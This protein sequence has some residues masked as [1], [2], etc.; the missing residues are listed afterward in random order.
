MKITYPKEAQDILQKLEENGFEAFLV[1]GS[2][3]DELLGLTP[4]DF[5]ITTSATPFEMKKIFPDTID[6]GIKHGTLTIKVNEKQFEVT[7]YRIDSE[8][9]DSRHPK[10]VTF[11]TSLKED[12]KRRDFTINAFAYSERT[13]FIDYFNGLKDLKDKRIRAIGDPKKRF[14]EDALRMLRAIRFSAQLG[15][16]I[17]EETKK[18]IK[19]EAYRL[20]YISKERIQEEFL[21]ILL[22]PHP[23][24]FLLAYQLGVTK[25]ILPEFDEMMNTSQETPYHECSVGE[26]TIKAIL[27]SPQ[28]EIIR[29]ALFFHDYGK[30]KTKTIDENGIA[31]FYNHAPKGAFAVK[32][33]L[34]RLKFPKKISET[35]TFLVYHHNDEFLPQKKYVRRAI[36]KIT[37]ALFPYYLAIQKADILAQSDYKKEEALAIN[38]QIT[39]LFNEIMEEQDCLSLKDLAVKGD[40][41]LKNG[42][43][44]KNIGKVLET[45]LMHILDEPIDNNKEYLLSHL[46]EFL[47]KGEK[48]E[49]K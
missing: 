28:D 37:P 24:C 4:Q 35:V 40:D 7:T 41:L 8:Y 46:N 10:E 5:D 6:A 32:E 18:A 15:F 48:N 47:K 42:I 43:Q 3:R 12:L 11:T 9:I 49:G 23:E 36:H 44:G 1:G 26:H 39:T 38:A 30:T 31:H 2:L 33:I 27:A 20:H 21:K 14:E 25:I 34:N 13:G 45:M 17:E 19:E 16:E 29:L 22:S